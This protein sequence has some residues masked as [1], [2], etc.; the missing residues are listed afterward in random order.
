[1]NS[2]CSD[3]FAIVASYMDTD[4]WSISR[5]VCR[6]WKHILDTRPSR[7]SVHISEPTKRDFERLIA[8]MKTLVSI[9]LDGVI[10][11]SNLHGFEF[12]PYVVLKNAMIYSG[13]RFK[14]SI[15][16]S[17]EFNHISNMRRVE[18][19]LVEVDDLDAII[20]FTS[21]QNYPS[22][23]HLCIVGVKRENAIIENVPQA[24]RVS[25]ENIP[26]DSS[27][28]SS[29]EYMNDDETYGEIYQE[30]GFETH[31]ELLDAAGD[32]YMESENSDYESEDENYY[33][34]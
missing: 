1:M 27:D 26:I 2:I 31:Q 30:Y 14:S 8:Q 20:N 13:P 17:L 25:F 10:L 15:Y 9:T 23:K 6:R 3:A 5:A 11:L 24:L 34:N 29:T 4:D 18:R 28:G 33:Y 21:F 32:Y 16:N 19:L 22:M 7:V 12:P